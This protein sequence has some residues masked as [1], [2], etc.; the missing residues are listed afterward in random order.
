MMANKDDIENIDIDSVSDITEIKRLYS[1]LQQKEV[2]NYRVLS[3]IGDI[4]RGRL[5]SN[6]G[7]SFYI[8][9]LGHKHFMC[10]I[11]DFVIQERWDG[12]IVLTLSMM[13]HIITFLILLFI[14]S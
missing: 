8:I 1:L 5:N 12:N 4:Y 6:P 14:I 10:K 3:P 2:I 13:C 7:R 11:Q 9:D